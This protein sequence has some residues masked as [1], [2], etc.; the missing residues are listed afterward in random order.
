VLRFEKKTNKF[1]NYFPINWRKPGD[2]QLFAND[3]EYDIHNVKEIVI[4]SIL[5][6]GEKYFRLIELNLESSAKDKKVDIIEIL[7]S[8]DNVFDFLACDTV[9][10]E[11]SKLLYMKDS[12][13]ESKPFYEKMSE[14]V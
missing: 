10:V 11:N 4:L 7:G 13:Q 2:L 1:L 3:I 5:S 9:L 14:Y 8:N 6:P 12:V